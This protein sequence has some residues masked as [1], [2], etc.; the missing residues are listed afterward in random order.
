L[1]DELSILAQLLFECGT[2]QCRRNRGREE[3]RNGGRQ[4]GRT[5]G[6]EGRGRGG[7]RNGRMEER[8][9][10][11]KEER[12]KGRKEGRNSLAISWHAK[13]NKPI[14]YQPR[15]QNKHGRGEILT[16]ELPILAQLLLE[17]DT[18]Q[19]TG[20]PVDVEV[21]YKSAH[22]SDGTLVEK[23]VADDEGNFGSSSRAI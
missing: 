14:E 19:C 12:E 20:N 10:R 23:V 13:F 16:D 18:A 2:A 1:T 21:D 8:K 9:V 11:K 17:C 7:G 6:R 3:G 4:E 5:E 22:V 15:L